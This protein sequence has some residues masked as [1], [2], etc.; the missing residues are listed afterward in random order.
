MDPMQCCVDTEPTE[1]TAE[2][3]EVRMYQPALMKSV[4]ANFMTTC[5]L[6]KTKSQEKKKRKLCYVLADRPVQEGRGAGQS[7][8]GFSVTSGVDDCQEGNFVIQYQETCCARTCVHARAYV[9]RAYVGVSSRY[10]KPRR[11][12]VGE[13]KR[14]PIHNE[15]AS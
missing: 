10:N 8:S 2:T 11:R 13:E 5:D 15:L 12:K 6:H 9:H 14:A 1:S 3:K 4:C 7:E